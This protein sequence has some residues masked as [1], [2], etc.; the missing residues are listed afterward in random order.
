MDIA[1]GDVNG[2]GKRDAV[3]TSDVNNL[4]RV[5]IGHGDGSF[6]WQ[7]RYWTAQRPESISLGDLNSDG[8]LDAVTTGDDGPDSVSVLLGNG[9][10]SFA[11]RNTYS[12]GSDPRKA[13]LG[14]LNGD[15]AL[16]IVTANGGDDTVSVLLGQ[17]DGSFS[18]DVPYARQ[19]KRRARE[20][21][22]E[23]RFLIWWW[24]TVS[25]SLFASE[26]VMVLSTIQ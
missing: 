11:S 21:S 20:I 19:W 23:M 14:D 22:T 5:L 3:V 18:T 6:A 15:G 25:G 26:R 9:N 2:D 13:L 1:F 4:F 8:N 7:S 12:V 24:L 17:G 10:G 16:D